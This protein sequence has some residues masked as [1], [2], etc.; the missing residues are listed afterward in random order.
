MNCNGFKQAAKVEKIIMR[1]SRKLGKVYA[2]V[3]SQG[4]AYQDSSMCL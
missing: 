3:L 4:I 1:I 2:I